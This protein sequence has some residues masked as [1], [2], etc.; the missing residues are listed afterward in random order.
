[1]TVIS[2]LGLTLC[3]VL[4]S[5]EIFKLKIFLTPQV[6][7]KTTDDGANYINT[8]N[9]SGVAE[10]KEREEEDHKLIKATPIL[11]S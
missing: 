4:Y 7:T 5:N 9:Q 1:M 3:K 11:V 10:D 6:I 2:V 8:F